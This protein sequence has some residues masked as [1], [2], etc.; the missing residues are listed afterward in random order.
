LIQLARLSPAVNMIFICWSPL[1]RANQNSP[2][3]H[4]HMNKINHPSNL[5]SEPHKF[6]MLFLLVCVLCSLSNIA[7]AALKTHEW[8]E[9]HRGYTIA[10][11]THN[12]TTGLDEYVAAGTIY[13]MGGTGQHGWHFMR[14]DETGQILA[15]RKSWFTAN[16]TLALSFR[17]VSVVRR[18]A[19]TYYIVIQVREQTGDT[20]NDYIYIAGVNQNGV[21]LTIN[22]TTIIKSNMSS[23]TNL[24][25]TNA[26]LNS[27]LY[28]CGY[29]ADNT[30]Y[31]NMPTNSGSAKYGMLLTLDMSNNPSTLSNS[32][33]WNSSN[34]VKD[35]DMPLRVCQSM[36]RHIN[37]NS[38]YNL[39]DPY[40]IVTGAANISEPLMSGVLAA[41]FRNTGS[42]V[43]MNALSQSAYS[44]Y[45]PGSGIA[46]GV[47]GVDIRS[48]SAN[49]Y[50]DTAGND[51][52]IL[53]DYF[54]EYSIDEPA[55]NWGIM[56]IKQDLTS[57]NS[58][59]NSLWL[60][61]QK[62]RWANQFMAV[63]FENTPITWASVA[64]YQNELAFDSCIS[65]FSTT[66][67][68]RPS[69]TNITP[70]LTSVAIDGPNWSPTTG[71]NMSPAYFTYHMIQTSSIGTTT[72]TMDYFSGTTTYGDAIEDITRMYNFATEAAY[73]TNSSA[74][75]KA[76]ALI[77]HVGDDGNSTSTPYLKTKFIRTN[78]AFEE[79]SCDRF[80]PDCYEPSEHYTED[81]PDFSQVSYSFTLS[82]SIDVEDDF[83]TPS[84]LDCSSGY[85]KTTAVEATANDNTIKIFPNPT[86]GVLNISTNQTL[87]KD[88]QLHFILTDVTGKVIQELHATHAAHN[89]VSVELPQVASGVYFAHVDI[90]GTKHVE[91]IIVQ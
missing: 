65:L 89:T 27:Y 56:R 55:F 26:F 51:Y 75:G 15:S 43:S 23:Y 74:L 7:K 2:Q 35:F 61:G 73:Y 42:L 22:P 85:Y 20:G 80:H 38:P 5:N 64:G 67:D 76:P 66:G 91:K 70:F 33:V 3:I 30:S 58:S 36:Q 9:H 84:E 6:N 49:E 69:M 18:N 48:T 39:L 50:P 10:F 52:V 90:N 53:F 19:S 25:A 24:Y 29:A 81:S 82:H 45:A 34:S 63:H 41:K 13:D 21:D 54:R 40:I 28:I 31:P 57:F 17:V 71:W 72:P 37:P 77:A 60:S 8:E 62:I 78:A 47:Y 11:A 88:N 44:G 1:V 12:T 79:L 59:V 16:D 4:L 87:S 32:Y 86:T 68:M 14:L 46:S 83:S